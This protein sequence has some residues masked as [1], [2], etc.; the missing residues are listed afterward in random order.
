MVVRFQATC[1]NE[2]WQLDFTPS[3]LK[4]LP[5]DNTGETHSLIF[6]S[7]IDDRSGM[8]YQEYHLSEG[9]NVLIALRFLFNAMSSKPQKHLPFQGIPLM[10]YLDNGPVT[11]SLV[12]QRVYNQL[13]IEIRPHMPAGSDRE[14]VLRPV[15][16]AR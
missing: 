6:A 3:E 1:S 12:F 13:G 14:G 4:R 8:M 2:C 5:Q 15:Q 11:K 9:E 10:I 7:V 16:K